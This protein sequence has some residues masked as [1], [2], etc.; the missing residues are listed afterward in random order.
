MESKNEFRDAKLGGRG[1]FFI[2]HGHRN[3]N[4]LDAQDCASS[5]VRGLTTRFEQ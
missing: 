2:D 4:S 5:T 1:P 3:K